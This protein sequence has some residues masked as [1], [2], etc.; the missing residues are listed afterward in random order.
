MFI[1]FILTMKKID[2]IRKIRIDESIINAGDY[3]KAGDIIYSNS[4][5]VI[6]ACNHKPTTSSMLK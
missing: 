5:D 2:A 4:D 1:E 6:K 3:L